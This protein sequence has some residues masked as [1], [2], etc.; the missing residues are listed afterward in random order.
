MA[1]PAN[2]QT[3]KATPRRQQDAREKGNAARSTELPQS[4]TLV[5]AIVMLAPVLTSLWAQLR[6]DTIDLIQNG[7]R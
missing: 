5:A 7:L 6:A 1:K 4:I 2:S 3:E